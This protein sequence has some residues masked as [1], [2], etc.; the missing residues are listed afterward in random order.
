MPPPN[1]EENGSAPQAVVPQAV[2]TGLLTASANSGTSP[3]V[4]DDDELD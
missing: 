4:Q 3:T 2:V 1:E